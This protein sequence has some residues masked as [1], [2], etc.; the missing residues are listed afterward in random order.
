MRRHWSANTWVL[1]ILAVILVLAAI[2]IGSRLLAGPRREPEAGPAQ[3]YDPAFK[4]GDLAP[5]FALPDRSGR[6]HRLSD[7]ARGDTL[8][9]FTCGC[10]S[11]LDLQTY[12]GELIQKLGP[13]APQVL[14]VTTMPKDREDT[15]YRDTRLKQTLLYEQKEGPVMEQYRGHPCPR[16]YRL[17]PDRRVAWIGPSPRDT[18]YLAEIGH[19]VAANLGFPSS[20]RALSG[21]SSGSGE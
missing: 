17:R 16:V 8:L 21:S 7:L 14:N 13:R 10:K 20:N 19:Q 9:C 11:C 5:D 15:W 2:D 6:R 4:M 1:T 3:R 12:V 18:P